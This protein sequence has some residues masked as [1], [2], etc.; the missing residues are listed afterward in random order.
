M[1]AVNGANITAIEGNTSTGAGGNQS[2]GGMVCR[3]T[4]GIKTV[5]AFIR[6]MSEDVK[7]EDNRMDNNPSPAHK[8]GVEWAKKSG[9]LT[10]NSAGDLKLSEPVTRQQFCTML[11]RFAKSIGKS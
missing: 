7:K 9:I 2:N 1:E 3:K 5:T 11:H 6:P 4:R 8:V 10:G